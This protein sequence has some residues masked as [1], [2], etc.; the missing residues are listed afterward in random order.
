[1]SNPRDQA[2]A[3]LR[4]IAKS[5]EQAGPR[6]I[7]IHISIDEAR[8]LAELIQPPASGVDRDYRADA[9]AL[10]RALHVEAGQITLHWAENYLRERDAL[11]NSGAPVPGDLRPSCT[12]HPDDRPAGPCPQRYAASECQK[13]A[14]ARVHD[15]MTPSDASFRDL[16]FESLYHLRRDDAAKRYHEKAEA[17]LAVNPVPGDAGLVELIARAVMVWGRPHFKHMVA[18][19]T[20]CEAIEAALAHAAPAPSDGDFSEWVRPSDPAPMGIG[21]EVDAAIRRALSASTTLVE[22]LEPEAGVPAGMVPDAAWLENVAQ[23][24]GDRIEAEFGGFVPASWSD[25]L[26]A[27]IAALP[28]TPKQATPTYEAVL[29]FQRIVDLA[30]EAGDARSRMMAMVRVARAEIA[31]RT[32]PGSV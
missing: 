16:V 8:I 17:A 3:I 30:Q 12:C 32:S 13:A 2:L 28:G 26:A 27:E 19:S 6:T 20:L 11:T 14:E 22:T 10:C 15:G 21:R 7:A 24:I 9:V 23:L 18:F 5:V 4:D 25:A 31:A 1:M 29:A